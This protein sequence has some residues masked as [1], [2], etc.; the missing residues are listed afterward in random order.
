MELWGGHEC[1]VN[2]VGDRFC[3]QTALTGHHDRIDD[4]ERFAAL[5]ITALRYPVLW[6]RTTP[7]L[8]AT[9]DFGWSDVRLA[10]LERFGIRPIIGLLHHGSGPRGTSLADPALPRHF[11]R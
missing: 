5:G 11:A 6:E 4:V 7:E 10:E 1:T 2:R 3:D 9:P 8:G